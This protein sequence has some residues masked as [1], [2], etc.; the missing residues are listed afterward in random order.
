MKVPCQTFLQLA[1]CAAALLITS[2]PVLAQIYPSR[3]I[4]MI[5]PI[6]A[7]GAGDVLA[8]TLVEHMRAS[9][10]RPIVIENIPG[11]GGSIGAGRVARAA[12]DGYTVG[13]GTAGNFVLNGAS[14][15]Y[16]MT[17]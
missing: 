8:R 16:L 17:F 12:P 9:L 7:G 15:R 4:T 10:G 5:V 1:A 2:Q 13:F 14:M 6:A 11:A 3:P